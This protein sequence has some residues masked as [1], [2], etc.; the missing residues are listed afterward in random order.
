M[1]R[2]FRPHPSSGMWALR[3]LY[4]QLV[5]RLFFSHPFSL[6]KLPPLPRVCVH[7]H[8]R[9]RVRVCLCVGTGDK[10][11]KRKL[12]IDQKAHPG[13]QHPGDGSEWH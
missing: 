12:N 5:D 6:S 1:L 3:F 2:L 7:V 11:W 13:S 9:V 4:L 10:G 8:V